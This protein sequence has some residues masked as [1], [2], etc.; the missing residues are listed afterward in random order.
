MA[1]FVL[2]HI[3]EALWQRF[4]AKAEAENV[5]IKHILLTLIEAWVKTP[6]PKP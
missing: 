1:S 5:Q 4:K 3:D 6:T 2:R